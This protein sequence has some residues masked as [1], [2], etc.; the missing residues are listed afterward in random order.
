MISLLGTGAAVALTLA[1]VY[2][3]AFVQCYQST[4][5]AFIEANIIDVAPKISGRIHQVLVDD[6]RV[7][8]GD[9]L[10]TIDP[11]DY[12]AT[13]RQKQAAL[14]NASAQALA[15]Q[16]TI[17]QQ[18][19]HVNTLQA[20]EEADK[21]TAEAD[22]ASAANAASLSKR[23]QE[24]F[25]RQ[26]VAPQDLDTARAN[27]Q[28]TQATLD[29]ALKKVVSDQAQVTEA[30][31]QVQTYQALLRS[32]QAL[33]LE[34][35]ANVESAR[36]SR[37]YAEIRAPENGR[38]TNKAVQPGNYIQTG[39]VM[40]SLV[41]SDIYIIANFKENQIGR[42]RPGQT[43]TI[44]IDSLPGYSFAGHVHS[45]QAGTG[46]RFSLLPPQNATGNYVKVVQR[47]PVKILFDEKPAT[48]LPIGPGES[49]IPTVVA[50]I[51]GATLGGWLTDDYSWRWV[52][53]INLPVGIFAII[54]CFLF[55]E[56]P[57]YLKDGKTRRVDYIGFGLLVIWI[58]CLQIMLDKG[59]DE[60]WFSSSFIRWLAFGASA[61]IVLFLLWE[62]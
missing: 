8:K 49:A 18:E 6:N 42:M 25:A 61:G 14:D 47:V 20:T 54:M 39:Q 9:L 33:I 59:Q 17:Q 37:S 34:A 43:A 52:F 24:L 57:P 38:I 44:R 23:S 13:L 56:D 50:P 51:L 55:L 30:R 36:L 4:D 45:I 62:L 40:L 2:Y 15:V 41:P 27:A 12:D 11:G 35:G 3:Y 19:A 46:A 28:A 16:A 48:M 26:A 7:K 5:D 31:Y 1:G 32:V 10:V 60:D 21:A 22:R 58:G 53:Y 29:G